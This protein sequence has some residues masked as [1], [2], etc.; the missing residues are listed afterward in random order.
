MDSVERLKTLFREQGLGEESPQLHKLLIYYA[1]L[2]KWNA[3]MNLTAA[4][5]R[6]DLESLFMEGIWASKI[7]PEHADLHLDIGSGAGFPAVILKI[8]TPHIQLEM[9]ESRSKKSLFLEAVMDA[10]EIKGTR[11]FHERLETFLQSDRGRAWDCITW[12]GVKLRTKDIL[13]LLEHTH[14]GTQFWMFHG[15][16]A[17]LQDPGIINDVFKLLRTEKF[18]GRKEWFLSVY[19]RRFM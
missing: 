17:A 7:Y 15:S 14:A 19:S 12:K 4:K 9:I 5:E 2:K 13:K 6:G 10:L 1:L 18:P 3:R 16:K 8:L 11:I